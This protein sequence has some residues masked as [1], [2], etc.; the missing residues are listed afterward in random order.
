MVEDS[1]DINNRIWVGKFSN[2]VKAEDLKTA[3]S[4]FGEV[5]RVRF[6]PN[7]GAPYAFIQFTSSESA[8]KALRDGE[9]MKVCDSSIRVG[10]AVAENTRTPSNENFKQQRTS[11][12]GDAREGRRRSPSPRPKDH[13]FTVKIENLPQDMSV[14]ELRRLGLDYGKSLENARVS[15]DRRASTGLVDY[16]EKRDADELVRA[17]DGKR[18]EGAETRLRATLESDEVVRRRRSASPRRRSRSPRRRSPSNDR[19]RR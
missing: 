6:L 3:F 17:L 4:E 19:R 5:S 8:Q 18:M 16:T 9:D 1:N 11:F 10:P 13:F 12:Y 7:K 2:S 14:Q 15:Q